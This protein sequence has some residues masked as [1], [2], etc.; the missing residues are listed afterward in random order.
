MHRGD[1]RRNL[2][3]F[4]MHCLLH[5]AVFIRP[6]AQIADLLRRS[7]IGDQWRLV[8]CRNEDLVNHLGGPTDLIHHP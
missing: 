2:E 8:I 6:R 1:H 4:L 7:F 5:E 3:D